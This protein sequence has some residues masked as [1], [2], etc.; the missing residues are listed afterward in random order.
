MLYQQALD[1][2]RRL[3]GDNHPDIA[4]VLH[5]I[6]RL[7]IRQQQFD[8]AEPLYLQALGIHEQ[9]LGYDHPDVA[10]ILNSLAALYVR[11]CRYCEAES[12]Y[13]RSLSIQMRATG[14]KHPYVINAY[15]GLAK[16]YL[17]Q[18]Q[19]ERAEHLCQQAIHLCVCIWGPEN[20]EMTYSMET[21]ATVLDRTD[22]AHTAIDMRA[23]V[24]CIRS[25]FM[26]AAH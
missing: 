20:M 1:L 11:Q 23:R 8:Q 13:Q 17:A 7:H 21:Y 3:L 25:A 5:N 19:F 14:E 26:Q 18:D 6:A 22:R 2:Q 12:L 4:L 16:L 10:V 15:H 9:T 24:Q